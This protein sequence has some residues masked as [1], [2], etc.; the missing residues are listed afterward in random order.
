MK[1]AHIHNGPQLYSNS[2]FREWLLIMSNYW[3]VTMIC[4]INLWI[5]QIL[6]IESTVFLWWLRRSLSLDPDLLS[7]VMIA[8]SIVKKFMMYIFIFAF[9]FL[10]S[11]KFSFNFL[12]FYFLLLTIVHFRCKISITFLSWRPNNVIH[13]YVR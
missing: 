6:L 4:Y 9:T 8:Q 1:C 5:Y 10:E 2:Y 13:W 11:N 3:I 12:L 7:V